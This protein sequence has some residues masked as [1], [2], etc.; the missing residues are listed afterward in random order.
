MKPTDNRGVERRDFVR[1]RQEYLLFRSPGQPAQKAL[2]P[3]LSPLV[4]RGEREKNYWGD[5]TQGGA[6]AS[7]ALGYYQAIP[8]G[9]RIGSLTLLVPGRL[10]RVARPARQ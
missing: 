6:R 9:F 4:P 7:L 8:P 10:S 5:A 1:H 3:A 2:S